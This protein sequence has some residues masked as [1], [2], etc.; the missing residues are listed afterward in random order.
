VAWSVSKHKV[1]FLLIHYHQRCDQSANST[2]LGHVDFAYDAIFW[3][4]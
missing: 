2:I 4:Y 3:Y 1:L